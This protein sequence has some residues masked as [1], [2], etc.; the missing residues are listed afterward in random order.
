MFLLL[1][2]PYAKALEE[3]RNAWEL[4]KEDCLAKEKYSLPTNAITRQ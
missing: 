1:M 2:L 4:V 3:L